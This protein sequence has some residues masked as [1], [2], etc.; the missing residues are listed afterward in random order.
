MIRLL[1]T[2]FDGT[3]VEHL[4]EEPVSTEFLE[5][6]AALRADGAVWAVNTGRA[7]H[8]IV[9]GLEEFGFPFAPDFVLTSERDVF[10]PEGGGWIP[11]G[12][13]NERCEAVHRELLAQAGPLID[14]IRNFLERETE[15]KLILEHAGPAGIIARDDAEMDRIVSFI[16]AAREQLPEFHYQRNTMYLRFC[17]VS[18]HKGAA[19]GELARLLEVPRERIFAIGDHHNDLSMLDGR[20]A[21]L[22]ACPA[23]AVVEV[24][25]TVRAAGGYVAERTYSAG[26][27]EAI[28]YFV[29]RNG[30]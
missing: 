18:Y 4:A 24:K 16:D 6:I 28:E 17:H 14:Q 5:R 25:E 30:D 21:A 8:H 11:Y 15:A 20:Y 7:V 19:L 29:G 2:D 23:N 1:S 12:D 27:A 13:W 9:E 26:V 3:L 10:R 22:T